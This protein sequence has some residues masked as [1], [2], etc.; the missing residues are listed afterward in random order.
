[1]L[2]FPCVLITLGATSKHT[3]TTNYAF[4]CT[5]LSSYLLHQA[6]NVVE[7]TFFLTYYWCDLNF[8]C[9]IH[10][11]RKVA[12]FVINSIWYMSMNRGGTRNFV[13]R[14]RSNLFTLWKLILSMCLCCCTIGDKPL[15]KRL[16]LVTSVKIIIFWPQANV[17]HKVYFKLCGE[18]CMGFFRGNFFI[19]DSKQS[20][21]G[22]ACVT[23]I[24]LF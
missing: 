19:S 6:L 21:K 1:M 12:S 15:L 4:A 3:T 14:G 17:H 2:V 11:G 10:L 13:W 8:V 5:N 16:S 24:F 23:R 9:A 20:V 22:T 18:S 7:I